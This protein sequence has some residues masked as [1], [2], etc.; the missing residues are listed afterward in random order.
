M[1][2]YLEAWDRRLRTA[3][4]RITPQRQLVLEAVTHLR[5]A[6]PEEILGEV[7]S[8]A[9]GV[10]LS[11]VY[12]TLEVLEQVTRIVLIFI[13]ETVRTTHCNI[14]IPMPAV[15]TISGVAEEMTRLPRCGSLFFMAALGTTL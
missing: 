4:F 7:Q 11:T 5:H 10:N 8:T 1:N 2:D 3:G 12:R 9:S 13:V 14:L 6:T 15:K